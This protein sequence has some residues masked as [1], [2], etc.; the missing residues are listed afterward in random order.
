MG[1]FQLWLV[2]TLSSADAVSALMRTSWAWPVCE[3]LHFTGLCFLFGTIGLFDLRLLGVAKHV[4]IAALHRLVPWGVGGYLVNVTTGSMF[5]LTEPDQYVFNTAFHFKMLFMALAG[6]NRLVPWGVGGYLVNVTTGSMFLLTEP[7]QYVFNT[8][9]HFKM[10]FMALA[11]LNV[12]MFYL[13]V[14]R[15]IRPIGA[16]GDLP[17][18]A[19][20]AGGASLLLWIGVMVCGRL[21]TFYRP[22]L[23]DPELPFL[24][25]CLPYS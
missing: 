1:E 25:N 9:F 10:L 3:T 11:G 14:F 21:L 4:P 12:A 22:Y 19:K 13:R 18:A 7:D 16:G 6:L 20:L 15:E 24:L 23:C 5:L 17:R 2:R 8:A